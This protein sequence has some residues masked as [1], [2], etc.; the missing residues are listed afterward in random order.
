MTGGS[1]ITL[2]SANTFQDQAFSAGTLPGYTPVVGDILGVSYFFQSGS[3]GTTSCQTLPCTGG[4]AQL[5]YQIIGGN[6]TSGR[7]GSAWSGSTSKTFM[8]YCR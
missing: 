5:F 6:S 4:S 1:R 2:L 8:V 7:T 3:T